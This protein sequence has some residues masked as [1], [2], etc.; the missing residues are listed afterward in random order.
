VLART[1]DVEPGIMLLKHIAVRAFPALKWSHL[2]FPVRPCLPKL[3]LGELAEEL[4]FLVGWNLH[5]QVSVSVG[6]R[7]KPSKDPQMRLCGVGK[8]SNKPGK[9]VLK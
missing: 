9:P 6:T 2:C 5:D 3:E 1:S 7:L 4:G 8:P